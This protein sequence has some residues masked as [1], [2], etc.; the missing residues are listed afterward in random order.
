MELNSRLY[1][2]SFQ[3]VLLSGLLALSCTSQAGSMGSLSAL[4]SGHI[5]AHAGGYW[6]NQGAAQ[7]ASIA[8]LTGDYF[9]V[10]KRAS[11]NIL[12]GLGYYIPGYEKGQ[13]SL[14]YG[15][16][17]T[18]LAPTSVKGTVVQEQLYENLS[19]SY[20]VTHYPVYLAARGVLATSKP[21]L[22][23]TFDAGL[24]PNFMKTS[25]FREQSLDGMTLPDNAYSGTTTTTFS[26][27]VGAGLR[28]GEVLGH[29]PL[30]CGYRFFYL[31][32]G[33]L[34]GNSDQITA[35]TTGSSYANALVCT[36]TV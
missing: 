29:M 26:A 16:D 36:V 8:T 25:G 18:Y 7:S 12:F 31:G 30:D 21:W 13:F 20:D 11:S 17:F 32:R 4:H 9:S 3:G 1:S 6:S 33:H 23:F 10:N 5:L 15:L 34:S 27:M 22:A 28:L 19:Y 24:G 14:S 2:R 35:L